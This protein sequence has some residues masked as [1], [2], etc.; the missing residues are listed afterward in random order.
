MA[1][2]IRAVARV[3]SKDGEDDITKV[4]A[5]TS[6]LARDGWIVEPAGLNTASFLRTAAIL[7]NHNYEHPVATPVA[8]TLLDNGE[9]LEIAI[10]WP[11]P[12]TSVKSDEVRA[13]VKTGVIRAVSIGFLPTEMEPI[14]PKQPWDGQRVLKADLLE[15]SFVG[16]PADTGAIVTQR[17]EK[18]SD[19]KCGASRT[20]PID[21][22][23]AWDGPAAEHAIF[24]WAGGDDFSPAKARKAFLAYNAA[25]PKERGSYKLPIALVKDGRL[26]VPKGAIRAAASRLP[27][28]DISDTCKAEARK[29]LDHYEEKADMANSEPRASASHTRRLNTE[30]KEG[31][32]GAIR[33]HERAEVH[34][35]AVGGHMVSMG[36]ALESAQAAAEKSRSAHDELGEALEA[37]RSEPEKA[38]EH[39]ERAIKLHGAIEKHQRAVRSAHSDLEGAHEDAEGAHESLGRSMRSAHDAVKSV[40]GEGKDHVPGDEDDAT[41]EDAD[42]DLVETS[43]GTEASGGS[44]NGRSIASMRLKA[45]TAALGL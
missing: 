24:E 23:D 28:T 6:E 20:L 22:S 35:K 32:A 8:T 3:E 5:S 4:I 34:H 29:V 42:S 14:D 40:L 36:N 18:E 19:W 38:A 17:S 13:L 15:C 30:Q 7:F 25:K 11:P 21:D 44:S 1:E 37:A 39:L 31:L 10:R 2:K 27:Q 26:T 33:H 16:V 43:S 9:K 41:T 45:R 12:G